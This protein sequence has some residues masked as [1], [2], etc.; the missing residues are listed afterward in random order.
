MSNDINRILEKAEIIY[1]DIDKW[2]INLFY[3][4]QWTLRLET[5]E[6]LLEEDFKDTMYKTYLELIRK[7]EE[8]FREKRN[9]EQIHNFYKQNYYDYF[10]WWYYN[11]IDTAV[12]LEEDVTSNKDNNL[13]ENN[14][15]DNEQSFIE[16]ICNRLEE[17]WINYDFIRNYSIKETHTNA[18]FYN[19]HE[20]S[21]YINPNFTGNF[22]F[23]VILHE[24]MHHVHLNISANFSK[25]YYISEYD[26]GAGF[27]EWV[28][29][30]LSE[31]LIKNYYQFLYNEHIKYLNLL[32]VRWKLSRQVFSE[33]LDKQTFLEKM[34]EAGFDKQLAF[35]QYIGAYKFP[36]YKETYYPYYRIL[37]QYELTKLIEIMKKPNLIPTA[38]INIE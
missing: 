8:F 10:W 29:I 5:D 25:F 20:K 35:T 37:N 14:P 24:F 11:P 30:V 38:I 17:I 7:E 1:K 2:I 9:F 4:N 13:D 21:I 36:G 22:K 33:D 19:F 6:S 31:M 34:K 28:G 26:F 3:W 18:A 12:Y 23:Y 16:D 32:I 15:F 27:R